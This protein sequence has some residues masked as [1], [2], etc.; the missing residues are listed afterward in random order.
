MTSTYEAP[1]GVRA[2]LHPALRYSIALLGGFVAS[3][4]LT[5]PLSADLRPIVGGWAM[6][7]VYA[8]YGTLLARHDLREKR[9]P[10][11]LT[12]TLAAILTGSVLALALTAGAGAAALSAIA[13]GLGLAVVLT[14][15]GLAGHVGFGDVKLALS[16]G[17][18]TG[19]HTWYFPFLAIAL[20]YLLAFP[21]AIAA[22]IL[23]SR[24]RDTHDLPFGPYLLAAGAII[25]LVAIISNIPL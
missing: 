5:A 3:T 22:A 23:K 6:I 14:C 9:L 8:V 15:I 2:R 1:Q 21:H 18:L 20:A 7:A 12:L 25:A 24:G 13:G 11:S 16:I 17:L 10:D 19:W 4:A